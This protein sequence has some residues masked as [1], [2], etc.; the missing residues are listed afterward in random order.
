M[1]HVI[2]LRCADDNGSAF[3]VRYFSTEDE[4]LKNPIAAVRKAL[5][6]FEDDLFITRKITRITQ[7]EIYPYSDSPGQFPSRIKQYPILVG[8]KTNPRFT[9]TDPPF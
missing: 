2:F 6:F 5:D 9:T 7:A 4:L 8:I 1:K 3:W